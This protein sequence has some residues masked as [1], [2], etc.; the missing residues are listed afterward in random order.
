M[1]A[2]VTDIIVWGAVAVFLFWFLFLRNGAGPEGG[3]RF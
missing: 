1:F 3:P 2:L